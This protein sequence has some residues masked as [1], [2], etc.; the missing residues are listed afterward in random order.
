[1]LPPPKFGYD[2]NIEK[3]NICKAEILILKTFTSSAIIML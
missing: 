3:K 1:M 2:K